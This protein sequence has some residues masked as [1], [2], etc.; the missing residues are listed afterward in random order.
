MPKTIRIF[1][2]KSKKAYTLIEL[3]CV[4]A[5]LMVTASMGVICIRNYNNIKNQVEVKAFSNEILTFISNARYYCKGEKIEGEI[6]ANPNLNSI[7]FYKNQV[8]G[9][10]VDK[11]DSPRDFKLKAIQLPHGEIDIGEDGMINERGFS[12]I[13]YDRNNKLHKITVSV[14]DWSMRIEE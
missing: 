7:V 1:L 12:I 10:I 11:L 9:E 8:K 6:F 3:I 2:R 13:Y 4:I 5:I 14:G